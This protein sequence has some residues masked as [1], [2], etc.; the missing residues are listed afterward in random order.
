VNQ[1]L[2]L[3]LDVPR[4]DLGVSLRHG[5]RLYHSRSAEDPTQREVDSSRARIRR[6]TIDLECDGLATMCVEL[7]HGELIKANLLELRAGG[8]ALIPDG[9]T[10]ADGAALLHRRLGLGCPECGH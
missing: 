8:F 7:G 9:C 5:A 6:I 4:T 3:T 1:P 2:Y 10:Q